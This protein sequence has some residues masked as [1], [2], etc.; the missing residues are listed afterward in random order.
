[1]RKYKGQRGL[2]LVEVTIMLL[3]L[4]LLTGVLAPSIFDFVN[5]ARWVKVKE[6]CEAIG[7]TIARMMRDVP[8]CLRVN[9]TLGCTVTNRLDLLFSDGTIGGIAAGGT[10]SFLAY[11]LAGANDFDAS[12]N[13]NAAITNDDSMERHFTRNDPGGTV[14]NAYPVPSA[15][16]TGI[17]VGP[18]FALGW[19]GA[20]MAGPIGPDPWG[21]AYLVNTIFLTTASDATAVAEGVNTKVWD[22][23]TFCIS[24]GPNRVYDTHFAGCSQ[25]GL[26]GTCR[27]GDDYTFVIQGST[28]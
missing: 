16:F 3:V 22:R 8:S 24:S 15:L 12:Y 27:D 26:W 28:R 2:S 17:P 23:D 5:D 1:M 10:G 25:V 4:M 11:T 7:V 14:A 13:W 19:R 6:D 9:G 21:G 20:Y 18:Q